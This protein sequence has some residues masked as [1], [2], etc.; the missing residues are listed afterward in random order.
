[1]LKNGVKDGSIMCGQHSSGCIACGCMSNLKR[2]KRGHLQRVTWDACACEGLWPPEGAW[3][4]I[5]LGLVGLHDLEAR[6]VTIICKKAELMIWLNISEHSMCNTPIWTKHDP[7]D[8]WCII[9]LGK[10]YMLKF[11]GDWKRENKKEV[12]ARI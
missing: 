3:T 7:Y 8:N 5:M 2:L 11:L 12:K 9:T 4:F 6:G 1:M 10:I